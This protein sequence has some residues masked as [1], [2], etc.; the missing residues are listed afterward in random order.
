[1]FLNSYVYNYFYIPFEALQWES[2][3]NGLMEGSN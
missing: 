1:M 3:G 2:Y